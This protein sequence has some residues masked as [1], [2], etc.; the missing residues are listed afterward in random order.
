M[1]LIIIMLIAGFVSVSV[2]TYQ[3]SISFRD[4][5]AAY[6]ENY[7]TRTNGTLNELNVLMPASRILFIKVMLSVFLALLFFLIS[8]DISP[9]ARFILPA[10]G[11]LIG[12]VVPDLILRSMCRMRAKKYNS[13]LPIAMNC[14][15]NGIHS[16]MS[17]RQALML[18][19]ED[20]PEPASQE[21]RLTMRQVQLGVSIES[22][23]NNM[24]GRMKDSDLQLIVNAIQLT[25]SVGGDLP[26][27]LKQIMTTIQERKRIDGKLKTMTSQG[28]M[29]AMIVGLAPVVLFI[30]VRHTNPE[31]MRLMYTTIP[32][33]ILLTVA[34]GLDVTGYF[35]IRKII[36]VRL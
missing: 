20:L 9:A 16:G 31:L 23:L 28:K 27:V 17:L 5:F 14:I 33:L 10:I 13:Q 15:C 21:F 25:M 4:G 1:L 34:A 19:A 6:E 8:L 3:F 36:M 29:Q 32:G 18:A 2:L 26:S 12:I 30:L 11:I 24:V 7:L 35:M 22:A